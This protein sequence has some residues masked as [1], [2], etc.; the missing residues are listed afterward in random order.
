MDLSGGGVWSIVQCKLDLTV[1]DMG[2]S[3]A[4]NGPQWWGA[5]N[6][7]QWGGGGFSSSKWTLGEG[8]MELSPAKVDLIQITWCILQAE[9][10]LCWEK[11]ILMGTIWDCLQ[12]I[13]DIDD[14]L[15]KVGNGPILVKSLR[16][17]A[18]NSLS[19]K[20]SMVQPPL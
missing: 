3:P 10:D 18:S 16:I 15:M 1:D 17:I 6:G 20:G 5:V 13:M 14:G 12:P 11:Q 9:I 4:V 8:T 19:V 7:P 2:L